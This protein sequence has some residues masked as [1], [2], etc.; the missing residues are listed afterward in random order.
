[1]HT[2]HLEAHPENEQRCSVRSQMMQAIH[3]SDEKCDPIVPYPSDVTMKLMAARPERI[4]AT[5]RLSANYK[6]KLDQSKCQAVYAR[7]T[8]TALHASISERRTPTPDFRVAQVNSKITFFNN[9]SSFKIST[10]ELTSLLD[11][12]KKLPVNYNWSKENREIT[13]PMNQGLCGSCWAVATATCLS[14]VFVVSKKTKA[15]PNISSTYVLSCFPQGQCNG[16]D[17]GQAIND[18]E[19]NGVATD[20]CLDYSWCT[21]TGCGGDPLKHFD[22]RGVNQYIPACKCNKP[23]PEYLRYYAD[24][25]EAICIPPNLD[26]FTSMEQVNIKYYLQGLYGQTGDEYANLSSL[27]YQDIQSLIKNH[28]YNYGPVIGGFHVFK[29]FFRGDYAETNGI[30]VETVSYGGV[31]GVNYNDVERDWVGSHAVVIVGWGREKVHGEEVDYWVVRNSWGT[32]WGNKGFWKMAMYGDDPVKKYENRF[33]QF[34][35]PSI[36]NTDEGIALTGGVILVKAGRIEAF[37]QG[38]MTAVVPATV[39]PSSPMTWFSFAVLT[40]FLF[41]LYKIYSKYP[42]DSALMLVGKTFV[43][44]ILTGYLLSIDPVSSSNRYSTLEEMIKKRKMKLRK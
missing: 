3:D 23:A 21:N 31:P 33:S 27:R 38:T 1:M 12:A 11:A 8:T 14:D 36:V 16:G 41:T 25:T 19:A 37:Q 40:L 18:M 32:D 6:Q 4:P 9:V 43:A 29:N 17:P 10:K 42:P 28:I 2:A 5:F 22:S 30:Y 44:L 26:D 24:G 15:N 20:S 34:E 13:Q 35:Y 39:Q 7:S